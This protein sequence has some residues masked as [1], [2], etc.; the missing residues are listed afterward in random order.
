MN[1]CFFCDTT[2]GTI[3]FNCDLYRIIFI[4]LETDYPGFIRIVLNKHVKEISDLN[5][6]DALNLFKAVLAS[7]K[8]IRNVYN[9]DKINVASLGNVTP[10]VHWH[11]IPR[12]IADKHYPNPIWGEIT[13][14]EYIP[15][16]EIIAAKDKLIQQFRNFTI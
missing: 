9:P 8:I 5:D 14:P 7:E 12:F 15:A 11:I 1:P 10:H 2:G 16:K 13:H 6:A 3:L 4:D